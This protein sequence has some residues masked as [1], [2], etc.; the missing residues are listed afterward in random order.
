M[1]QIETS[2]TGKVFISRAG[3]Y[4]FRYPIGWTAAE[5]DVCVELYDPE[6]GVGVL[7]IS[8][9][10]TPAP[11][12]P[13]DELLDDLADYKPAPKAEDITVTVAATKKVAS[14]E[15][16]SDQSFQK[17]WYISD[18]SYL[19]LVTYNCADKNK[20]KELQRVEKI[21]KSIEVE[22]KISRN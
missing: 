17:T 3:W 14:F 4:S 12:D 21:V 6:H 20:A 10:Q 5:D 16:V 1:S 22:P 19:V 18:K 13:K 8:A 2:Q 9:Y 7:H 11:I 15:S